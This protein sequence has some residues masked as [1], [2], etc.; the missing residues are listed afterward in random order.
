MPLQPIS[1]GAFDFPSQ[2][3]NYELLLEGCGLISQGP[4]N[5]LPHIFQGQARIGAGCNLRITE[6]SARSV[7]EVFLRDS[8]VGAC[9]PSEEL[10]SLPAA[11]KIVVLKG[12][13]GVR[14]LQ[15]PPHPASPGFIQA[16]IAQPGQLDGVPAKARIR[17]R[18][19]ASV[20]GRRTNRF[21]KVGNHAPLGK[22][23]LLV[24]PVYRKALSPKAGRIR[25]QQSKPIEPYNTLDKY[26]LAGFTIFLYAVT[27]D[28][29]GGSDHRLFARRGRPMTPAHS[30]PLY[31]LGTQ[32]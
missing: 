8:A 7:V 19:P 13:L 17:P 1:G 20:R 4:S 22:K 2:L 6:K 26:W 31:S 3:H 25:L 16:R 29:A 30:G 24:I 32:P 18:C 23:H 27:S 21:E 11:E 15:N 12:G 9:V 28:L 10:R 5:H 14:R